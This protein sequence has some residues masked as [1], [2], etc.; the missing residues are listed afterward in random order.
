MKES[1][2]ALVNMSLKK[3]CA[4]C[5]YLIDSLAEE[6]WT[7]NICLIC[8]WQQN[9]TQEMDPTYKGGPNRVD[10][11]TARRNYFKV[12]A[13]LVRR[14]LSKYRRSPLPNEIP[15][16]GNPYEQIYQ[17]LEPCFSC[18]CCFYKTFEMETGDTLMACP[19][20]LWT[21]EAPVPNV[22]E[23]SPEWLPSLNEVSLE[24]AQKNFA[25]WRVYQKKFLPFARLPRPEETP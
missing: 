24:D 5:G 22:S 10:L 2:N 6:K 20:C 11:L 17:H 19:V 1:T 4:C 21:D 13:S 7:S 8:G 12:G 15:C 18:P 23:E 25:K 9:I 14:L 16:G 3:A